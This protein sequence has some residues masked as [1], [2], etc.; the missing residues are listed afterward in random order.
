M[1]PEQWDTQLIVTDL[2]VITSGTNGRTQAPFTLW[3]V[4][5]TKP[6]GQAIEAANLRTFQEL[7]KHEIIEVQCKRFN[8]PQY[9]ESITLTKKG[10]SK[11]QERMDGLESR[12]KV[13]EEDKQRLEERLMSVEAQI[14]RP[15][16]AAPTVTPETYGQLPPSTASVPM[17][18]EDIPF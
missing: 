1:P 4:T 18:D 11:S 6:N 17:G 14:A 16:A 3:Q 7:P 15:P 13:L 2:K 5:A 9:G 8:S 10:K 12:I